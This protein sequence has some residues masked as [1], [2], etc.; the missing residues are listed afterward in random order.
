[1]TLSFEQLVE[2]ALGLFAHLVEQRLAR[3]GEAAR[4]QL[5]LA[6]P[7]SRSRRERRDDDQDAVLGEVPPVAQRDVLHVADAEPVDEGDA[8]LDC[9]STMRRRDSSSS[10]TEP[11]SASTIRVRGHAASRGELRVRRQHAEL[12]V[13]RHDRTS[14]GRAPS[15][16]RSSSALPWPETCTGAISWCRTSAPD[17]ASRLIASWTRSSFPGTGLAEMITVSPALDLHRRV[18]VVGDPRQ[19]RERLALAAGAEDRAPRRG[20]YVVELLRLD[21]ATSSGTSM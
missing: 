11:F 18:V 14:A 2:H 17:F 9:R 19:R 12:A 3:L 1:M 5:G 7:R 6:A 15:I 10:T 16:V 13:D 21:A 20:A 8:G 4:D